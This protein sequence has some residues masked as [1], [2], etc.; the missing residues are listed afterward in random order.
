[1]FI[2]LFIIFIGIPIMKELLE[3]SQMRDEAKRKGYNTYV[4][5]NGGL[6]Y[7]DSN[8]PYQDGKI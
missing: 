5:N 3:D 2:L 4:A 8:K 6:K 1:M 7:V